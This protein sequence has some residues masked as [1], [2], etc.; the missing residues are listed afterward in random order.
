MRTLLLA[1]LLCSCDS[2]NGDS[3]SATDDSTPGGDEGGNGDDG[4]G[5]DGTGDDS[6]T[7]GDLDGDGVDGSN[8]CN[9]GDDSIYPG[10]FETIG[11]GVDQDCDG[12]DRCYVDDDGDTFGGNATISAKSCGDAGVSGIGGDCDDADVAYHPGAKESCDE[13]FD[14]NC[15]D[16]VEYAD[17]DKDGWA[18]C[19]DCDDGNVAAY[20]E[21]IEHPAN[22]VDEDCDGGDACFADADSDGFGG[23]ALV[24]SLDLDCTDPGEGLTDE[25]CLDSGDGAASTWPGIAFEDST[26]SCMTDVD[27]DGYGSYLPASGVTAGTDCNDAVATAHPGGTDVP[28]DGVDG[29]CDTTETCYFDGDGDGYG[30]PKVISSIDADCA[31]PGEGSNDDDCD[32]T[33]PKVWCP[34]DIHIGNDVEFADASMHFPDYLLGPALV[35]PSDMTLTALALIGK[36]AT[37]NVRMALYTDSSGAPD[38]LV[39]STGS[40]PVPVGL[41]EIPVKPIALT[42]GTYWLMAVY[43]TKASIG[44]MTTV[45]KDVSL[46]QSMSFSSAMPDPFGAASL[47]LNQV[48]NYYIVGY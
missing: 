7:D 26:T 14:Y 8:D 30:T 31:D 5:D 24:D 17:D 41:L 43:D 4:T 44:L 21:G 38:A 11:D 39:T 32:D 34:T 20:P 42:A 37:G 35:V 29:D 22:G 48:F 33:D 46:Y 16:S 9:D 19:E 6:S 12:L 1:L 13:P 2:K 40:T 28:G 25:D 36:A 27:G 45:T 23:A 47:N 18:A 15:D 3:A 10:A